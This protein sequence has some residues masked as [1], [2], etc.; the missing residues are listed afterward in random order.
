MGEV[1][2][3]SLPFLAVSFFVLM[4][5]TLFPEISLF[6]PRLFMD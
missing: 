2:K 5:V 4:L 3:A 1:S 6:F